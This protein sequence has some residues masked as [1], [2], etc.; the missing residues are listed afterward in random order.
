MEAGGSFKLKLSF[1]FIA[2]NCLDGE[3]RYG[4]LDFFLRG[5]KGGPSGYS[6]SGCLVDCR[7]K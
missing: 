4:C 7:C 2:R 6:V 1:I 3:D 5:S